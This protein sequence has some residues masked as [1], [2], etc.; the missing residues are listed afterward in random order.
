MLL[1]C[2]HVFHPMLEFEIV[3]DQLSSKNCCF[4]VFETI[5][6]YNE[7]TKELVN[8]ELQ[9]FQKHKLMQRTLSVF[10]KGEENMSPYFQLLFS[11]LVRSLRLLDL[12]LT[13]KAFFASL[14]Y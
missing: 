4:D 6:K 5:V 8:R 2:H 10:C 14:K 13:W 3:V 12:K 9:M 11:L 1:K 7:I